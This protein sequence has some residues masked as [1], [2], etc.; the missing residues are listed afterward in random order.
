V[1]L[2]APG[3]TLQVRLA[4]HEAKG[5]VG[6][7][8]SPLFHV[9]SYPVVSMEKIGIFPGGSQTG[10]VELLRGRPSLSGQSLKY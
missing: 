6:Q 7:V 1:F 3:F 10:A 8:R 2:V 5:Q 4:T 9:A